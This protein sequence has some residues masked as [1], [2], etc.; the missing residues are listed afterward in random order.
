MRK[1]LF[2]INSFEIGG[3]EKSLI[4]LLNCI[5]YKKFEVDLMM[6]KRGGEF[7][8]YI[9]KEV[10]ILGIPI[11]YKFINNQ[12]KTIKTKEK[13]KFLW[14]RIKSSIELRI[15][16]KR[17]T[18]KNNQQIFYKNQK[19]ILESI[20]KKYDIA[21]AYSQGFPTYFVAEKI[22]AKKK[23]AWINCDY[24][25]TMYDKVYDKYFYNKFDNIIAV[26]DSCKKSIIN[27]DKSYKE[28]IRVIKDIVNPEV[29]KSM[30]NEN[31][32]FKYDEE[33]LNILTVARLV[34][35]YKGYDLVLNAAKLLEKNNIKF[36]WYI[37]GEGQDR[38]KIEQFIKENNLNNKIILLGG[39]SNPY[40]YMKKC[41][42]YVQTSRIEG[43]GL[44]V[45]EALILKKKIVCTN[46]E[47]AKEMIRN[48]ENGL[49][50]DMTEKAIYKGIYEY[51][52]NKSLRRKIEDNLLKENDYNSLN[53]F[54]KILELIEY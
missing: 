10:N 23:Y 44:T 41:D 38:K 9:P 26:S 43:F 39:K 54:N 31:I 12:I 34:L 24:T 46:F 51:I 18:I 29:I 42:I 37:L 16:N 27:V 21:V 13:I 2:F 28:K 3:G 50:V 49:L 35:N 19:N 5:S 22:N 45:I 15:I 8:K 40:P 11:Y 17:S 25:N 53:E 30:A 33:Y 47:A 20:E 6:I 36:R 32:D 48:E 14:V 52:N 7:E 1:I 4:A